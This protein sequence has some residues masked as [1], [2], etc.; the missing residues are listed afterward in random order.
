M[1]SSARR[2]LRVLEAV[3]ASSEPAG[4]TGLARQ[5]SL[6]PG[7]VFRTLDAL[8]RSGYVERYQASSRY[9]AGPAPR[10]LQH[11]LFAQFTIRELAQPYLQQLASSSGETASLFVPLGWYA[12][13]V[14]RAR[15]SNEVTSV[16]PLGLVGRL[17]SHY[18]GRAILAFLPSAE[19]ARYGAA[20]IT[21]LRR[22][23]ST[24]REAGYATD[25]TGLAKGRA[26]IALPVMGETLAGKVGAIAAIALEGP[27]LDLT[28]DNASRIERFR[29][30]AA[31]LARTARSKPGLAINPFGHLDP[32]EIRLEKSDA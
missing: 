32:D 11:A 4:V 2:A 22:T 10:H 27:V 29:A 1:S 26:A 8:K 31:A 20:A 21:D 12:L 28:R 23:L 19:V 24:I 13:R 15:G 16:P 17:G 9:V 5:L 25:V 14:A 7:T 18:A 30:I 3:A 6:P